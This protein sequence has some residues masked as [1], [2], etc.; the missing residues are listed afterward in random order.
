MQSCEQEGTSGTGL[1][2]YGWEVD[3]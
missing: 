3:F 1:G 2:A